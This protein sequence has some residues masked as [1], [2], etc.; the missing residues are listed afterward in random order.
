MCVAGQA[1]ITGGAVEVHVID[2]GQHA[3]D[4]PIAQNLHASTVGGQTLGRHLGCGGH[5]DRSGDIRCAGTDV[6]L[7]TT[8][9]QQRHATGVAAQQQRADT[10]GAAELVGRHTHRRQ[11]ARHEFDWN[12]ADCLD[13]VA[14]HR[15]IEFC[16]DGC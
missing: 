1:G 5:C 9:V 15:H 4:E 10:R 7:L 6:A 16:C 3:V 8:S 2:R 14:V 11:P 13:R 12:L